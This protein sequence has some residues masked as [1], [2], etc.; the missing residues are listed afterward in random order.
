MIPTLFVLQ[1]AASAVPQTVPLAARTEAVGGPTGGTDDHSSEILVTARRKTVRSGVDAVDYYRRYC[2]DAN[3]LTGHSDMPSDDP[4]WQPLDAENRLKFG[5]TDA[6]VPAFALADP[7]RRQTLLVKGERFDRPGG[8]VESRCTMVVIGGDDQK[9][10]P[11]RISGVFKGSGTQRHVGVTEGTK[12]LDGW[13]QWL[14]TGMPARR[15]R[16]WSRI[17]ANNTW[18]IVDDLKFYEDYDYIL[19]DLKTKVDGGTP[20]STMSFAYTTRSRG[21]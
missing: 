16:S 3:R 7:V 18:L 15:S 13:R 5:I 10:L 14:W 2:F 8:L 17:D 6:S 9:S 11:K 1:I 20:V 21:H 4:D 19:G 12:R